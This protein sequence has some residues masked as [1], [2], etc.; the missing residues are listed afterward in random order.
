MMKFIF[1]TM[2]TAGRT[3]LNSRL[4]AVERLDLP[5]PAIPGGQILG[6]ALISY[7]NPEEE[8]V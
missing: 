7:L 2:M 6:M 4:E 8:A 3:H 1:P 5:I